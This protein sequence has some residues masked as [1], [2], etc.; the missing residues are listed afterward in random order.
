MRSP[1]RRPDTSAVFLTGL[2]LGL[3][4]GCAIGATL[5]RVAS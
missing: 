3:A 4:L 5:M 1:R 2:I